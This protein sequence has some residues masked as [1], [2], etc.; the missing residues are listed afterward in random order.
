MRKA[1]ILFVP[2]RLLFRFGLSGQSRGE[3]L[4]RKAWLI[5]ILGIPT[6]WILLWCRY[7]FTKSAEQF[8]WVHKVNAAVDVIPQ[9]DRA[10]PKYE[11]ALA[12]LQNEV[13]ISQYTYFEDNRPLRSFTQDPELNQLSLALEEPLSK[14]LEAYERKHRKAI[15]LVTEGT[16]RASP[17]YIYPA[18]FEVDVDNSYAVVWPRPD[19]DFQLQILRQVLRKA[20][21]GA[22]A[23]KDSS[24][25]LTYIT[26]M[27]NLSQHYSQLGPFDFAAKGANQSLE[28][29]SKDIGLIVLAK[30]DLMT[31]AELEQVAT[32]LEGLRPF[33]MPDAAYTQ[34]IENK[35]DHFFSQDGWLTREAI[36][37][38]ATRINRD[39]TPLI[40]QHARL[41]KPVTISEQALAGF[42]MPLGI[43][44]FPD[45]KTLRDRLL[46]FDRHRKYLQTLPIEKVDPS[47]RE[48]IAR[49]LTESP[50]WKE[51][52]QCQLEYG[53][54]RRST[55][56]ETVDARR[57]AAIV[58]I[59]LELFRR[60]CGSWPKNLAELD[61]DVPMDPYGH[62][63]LQ[64]AVRDG[65]PCLWSIGND[66]SSQPNEPLS[67][68]LVQGHD[69]QL[70][71][72]LSWDPTLHP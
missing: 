58:A 22:A 53:F 41:L 39:T 42:S 71:P 54:G 20:L 5:A 12:L 44:L 38:I 40:D 16:D 3:R 65:Q 21:F 27:L 15:D 59:R 36:D 43:L 69:W 56:P 25:V 30:P 14:Q 50:N 29:I 24:R 72:V 63:P 7:R 32:I 51:L 62:Q 34:W 37:A 66:C 2:I 57:H 55:L 17:G 23:R 10:W 64:Y 67:P 11:R 1:R 70:L 28:M 68:R 4:F 31:N 6:V 13:A 47:N 48:F 60:K 33:R 46:E 61:A 52:P 9:S 18:S 26:A 49:R 8:N 19:V 35:L 45:R